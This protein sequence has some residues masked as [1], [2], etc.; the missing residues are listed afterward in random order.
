M[1][2]SYTTW[3][4]AS[5]GS[6]SAATLLAYPIVIW[7]TGDDYS[8]TL[9]ST[10]TANLATYL[11]SGGRLFISGQDIGY[12]IST[13]AFFSNYLHATYIAD[14]TN[15]TTL[16]GYDIMA[17]ANVT[18][19]GG[20]GASNQNYPSAMGLATG[21]VGLYDYT[22]TTYTWGV[23]RWEGAYRV[24]YFA[25]GFEGISAAATLRHGHGQCAGLAG[26]RGYTDR[27]ADQYARRHSHTQ[28]HGLTRRLRPMRP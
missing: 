13:D 10:D 21:A 7:L 11:N 12:D 5:S 25:F 28:Q 20:D 24:V 26:G 6:P 23:L 9:T 27:H 17:G 15:V 14:D 2:R 4:V 22:G 18:I 16:T 3:T 8:T 19:T 1:G